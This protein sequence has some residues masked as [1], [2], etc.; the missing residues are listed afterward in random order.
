LENKR[1]KLLGAP[2]LA[3][4]LPTVS[5]AGLGLPRPYAAY[6]AGPGSI[7]LQ[8]D[9]RSGLARKQ[10]NAISGQDINRLVMIDKTDFCSY[11]P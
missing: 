8:H 7:V 9:L 1:K 11:Q 3:A 10:E 2:P 5:A 6:A 4:A